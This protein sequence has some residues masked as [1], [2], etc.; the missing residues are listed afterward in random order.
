[1]RREEVRFSQTQ[2]LKQYIMQEKLS[3][4]LVTI[5]DKR[6]F[7]NELTNICYSHSTKSRHAEIYKSK[8]EQIQ[9]MLQSYK[10]KS[11]GQCQSDCSPYWWVKDDL[12]PE[13]QDKWNDGTHY[14]QSCMW[15]LTSQATPLQGT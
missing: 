4:E 14:C 6:A 10:P 1:M 2:L 7:S 11:C 8:N 13:L 3:K 5:G 15:S 12:P 9:R